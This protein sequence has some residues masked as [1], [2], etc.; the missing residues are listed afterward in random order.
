MAFGFAQYQ[1]ASNVVA[2]PRELEA[3]VFS[4][5]NRHLID[6]KAPMERIHALHRNH[7]LWSLLLKDVALSTNA[8]P[9]SLKQ[10]IISLAL[11]AMRY[12]T[13]AIAE[14]LPMAPLIE[15]NQNMVE[16]LTALPSRPPPAETAA[17]ALSGVLTA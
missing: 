3:Q 5:V 10:N 14:P 15:V 8:L 6:A 1:R 12:S 17:T 11:W 9:D 13:V 16:A 7:K 2:S 4:F